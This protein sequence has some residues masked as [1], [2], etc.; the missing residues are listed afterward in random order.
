MSKAPRAILGVVSS[1]SFVIG[2]GCA[3]PPPVTVPGLNLRK[4]VIYRNGVGYFERG[5]RVQ[6]DSV[7]F[8]VRKDEVGD[9]LA[10]LAVL[11]RGG[12]S[13]RSASFPLEVEKDDP[14]PS[15]SP[16][17]MMAGG[18][19]GVAAP[20]DDP[21]KL[22]RVIMSL[23]GKEH[24]LQVGYIAQ[25]PVW[26]PS[27]R[28]VVDKD[29]ASLQTWGIV[30]N[31]SGEDWTNVS[32]SLV[33]EAPLAFDASLATPVIPARPT[34]TD[35]GDVIAVVPRAET[36][37]ADAPAPP[38]PP[39]PEAIASPAE[40]AKAAPMTSKAPAPH[41]RE[42]KKGKRS[43]APGRALDDLEGGVAGNYGG[44]L[45]GPA[46]QAAPAYSRQTRNLAA[47]AAI[48]VQSGTTRY[49]LP[50][51]VTIPDKSA[52]MV[53][54]LDQRVPGEIIALYAPDGGVPDSASH[55]FRVARFT[56]K[57]GGLLEKGPLAIF[58]DGAFVG[59][60][61]TDPL[62]D[63]GVATVPFAID[64]R[65]A[66]DVTREHREE[67]ARLYHIE[68]AA[69]TIARDAV[70]L[71]KYRLKNGADR[72]AKLMIKHPRIGGARMNGFPAGTED[73]VGT[74]SAL[75]PATLG[76]R[77]TTELVLDERQQT[78]RG[79]DWL[80]PLADDA[81][82]AYLRDKRADPVIAAQLKAAWE[83]R[84]VLAKAS[85]DRQKLASE[86]ADRRAATEETRANLKALEKNTAAADLRAKLTERLAADS[87]RLD[88]L[89]KKLIELNLKINENQV[90]FVEAIR[91]VKLLQPLAAES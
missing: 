73:N 42:S 4:V 77:A 32:L 38:P 83:I 56:N 78:T 13:V 24:D 26:R 88:V 36:S 89:S 47:L 61:M 37:L 63:A 5:G 6:S 9:F 49:D 68:G 57:T 35:G 62:P 39:A 11:E 79:V 64:R 76:P 60:G 81:V 44:A 54:L 53:M 31:L 27:Y 82:K 72:A 67:G 21:N 86:E 28:L 14:P 20:G 15:P 3:T 41:S 29:A 1:L 2:V 19:A 74:G 69:L 8:K 10:T 87:S 23:D 80:E 48:G 59:Q 12:S 30:Q 55:P 52:T 91:A 22:H 85:D 7:Q 40:E 75:V 90:R 46:G 33:A 34:V 51:A 70:S 50:A 18:K 58:S 17:P 43:A 25:T 66:I 45:R 84:Q 65:V 71:T 16:M